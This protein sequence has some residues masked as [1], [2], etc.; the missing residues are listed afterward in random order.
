M[1]LHPDQFQLWHNLQERS[2]N[3]WEKAIK[4]DIQKGKVK[5]NIDPYLVALIF[6]NLKDVVEEEA[7]IRDMGSLKFYMSIYGQL[8]DLIKI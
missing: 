4:N 8:Y 6:A 2:I 5:E 3:L 1:R 7:D